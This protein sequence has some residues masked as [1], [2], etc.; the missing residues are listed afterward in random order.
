MDTLLPPPLPPKATPAGRVPQ[1]GG[2]WNQSGTPSHF[3]LFPCVLFLLISPTPPPLPRPHPHKQGE[4]KEE[5]SQVFREQGKKNNES[6]LTEKTTA[7][8]ATGGNGGADL[9]MVVRKEER[10]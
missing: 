5:E 4:D 7:K 9:T 3:S 2:W 1:F 8:T 6:C 10:I